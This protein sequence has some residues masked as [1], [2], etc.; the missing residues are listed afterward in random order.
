MVICDPTYDELLV[1]IPVYALHNELLAFVG[2]NYRAS[3]LKILF[4]AESHYV[5]NCS[6]EEYEK[7]RWYEQELLSENYLFAKRR[8]FHARGVV[9]AWI[10]Q[11]RKSKAYNVFRFPAEILL[12]SEILGQCSTAADAYLHVAFMNYYQRPSLKSGKS[13]IPD[14][15]DKHFAALTLDE[16]IKILE[17]T[18]VIFLSKSAYREYLNH[19]PAF[20]K[21]YMVAHPCSPWWNRDHG[22]IGKLRLAQILEEFSGQ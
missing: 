18:A 2:A 19:H 4:V 15:M 8:S 10:N 7:A 13:I 22:R 12:Q 1:Q 11:E 14:E 5:D 21:I 16:V 20:E 3:A 17:P 6:R 9:K